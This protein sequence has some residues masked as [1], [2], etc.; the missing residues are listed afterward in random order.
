MNPTA[1][2]TPRF[3]DQMLTAAEADF[4]PDIADRRGEQ[5]GKIGRAGTAD[6]ERQARQQLL[7]QAG[8][9]RAKLVTLA[10]SEERALRGSGRVVG[11]GVAV[12]GIAPGDAHRKVWYSRC[13]SRARGSIDEMYIC[14]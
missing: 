4:E 9:M 10:P 2:K 6:V 5:A 14:S 3:R 11:R 7:D 13:S 8:L 12:V 1:G